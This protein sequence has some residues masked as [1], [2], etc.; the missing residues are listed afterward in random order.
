MTRRIAASKRVRIGVMF[1]GLL[2]LC[3]LLFPYL[4]DLLPKPERLLYDEKGVLSAAAP[5]SPLQAPPF[6]SDR[7]GVPLLYSIL[8]GAKYTIGF[9]FFVG[10]F[11][12][13]MGVCMGVWLSSYSKRFK[14]FVKGISQSFYNIPTIFM[15]YILMTPVYISIGAED[16]VPSTQ[17]IIML[18]QLAVGVGVA[19]PAIAVY[20][21]NEVDEQMK[22]E[23][24]IS[25][26]VMGATKWHLIR[27]HIH[28]FLREKMLILFMQHVVQTLI[29][30]VHL[31]LLHRFI[32]GE[33]RIEIDPGRYKYV[34]LTSEWS[35]LIGIDRYEFNLAPWIVLS[36]LCAFAITIF[37]LNLITEGIKDTLNQRVVTHSSQEKRIITNE[38][39]VSDKKEQFTFVTPKKQQQMFIDT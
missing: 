16:P 18:Y 7:L 23:Y 12:I 38:G 26:K 24:V 17:W 39:Q 31:G 4:K 10:F 6:G 32:G 13:L 9:A 3:S 29:L 27:T 21:T 1:L 36:P 8:E 30:F 19:V 34:S 2:I 33:R 28:L 37:F 35:G 15:A 11:R 22:Q 14:A 5:F 25:A 20:I